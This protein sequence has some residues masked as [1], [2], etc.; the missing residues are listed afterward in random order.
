M[1]V[2]CLDFEKALDQVDYG[3]LYLKLSYLRIRHELLSW[4][5]EFLSNRTQKVHM[6]GSLSSETMVRSDVLV[7][8][9]L[10]PLLFLSM[11]PD[12]D[13][14]IEGV[15]VSSFA[16]DARSSGKVGRDNERD[17]SKTIYESYTTGHNKTT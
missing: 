2:I 6:E 1:D 11:M 9:V 10:G 3:V 17:K 4:I 14:G 16:D 12:I 15:T 5:T 13:E 7:G 8:S